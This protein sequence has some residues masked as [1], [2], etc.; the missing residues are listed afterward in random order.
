MVGVMTVVTDGKT[1]IR[2]H[3]TEDECLER[4]ERSGSQRRVLGRGRD[5]PG[6]G[7]LGL[8]H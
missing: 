6:E 8:G 3:W 2:V 4:V 5:Q 1:G 7:P